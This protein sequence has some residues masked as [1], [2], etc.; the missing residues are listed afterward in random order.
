MKTRTTSFASGN[1]TANNGAMP[2]TKTGSNT[3]AK[4]IEPA[5]SRF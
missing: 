5:E 3:V 2:T 4:T 1:E